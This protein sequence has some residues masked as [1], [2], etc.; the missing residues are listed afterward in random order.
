M[1]RTTSFAKSI[2][3]L[4]HEPSPMDRVKSLSHSIANW[5]ARH[6]PAHDKQPVHA[7]ERHMAPAPA[8]ELSGSMRYMPTR[9][10]YNRRMLSQDLRAR[11]AARQQHNDERETHRDKERER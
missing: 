2:E 6:A 10:D 1:D 3:G 5:F 4:A 11:L 9:N 8:P 7:P